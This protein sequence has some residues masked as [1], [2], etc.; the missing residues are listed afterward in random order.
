VGLSGTGSPS[1]R[2]EGLGAAGESH[3]ASWVR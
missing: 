2:A 1:L 3:S